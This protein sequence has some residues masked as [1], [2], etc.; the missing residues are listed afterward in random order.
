MGLIRFD[1]LLNTDARLMPK[2]II[3]PITA[4]SFTIIDQE[5]GE[6]H[7]DQ[8]EYEIVRRVIHTTADFDFKHLMRFSPGAIASGLSAIAQSQTII[9]DVGMVKQGIEG[10]AARTFGNPVVSALEYGEITELGHE[11][12]QTKSANGMKHCLQAYPQGIFAVGNAPT[13]LLAL[14]DAIQN[15]FA[16]N[17]VIGV[18]V[19][20]VSVLEAK[21]SLMSSKLPFICVEGR[22]GGSTVAAAIINALLVIAWQ[23]HKQV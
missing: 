6:H 14:C 8:F 18:P 23:K 11:L 21:S 5:I 7:F 13:A 20:F 1:E 4:Q 15:G 16:P 10:M 12:G 9:T 19:G 2:N 17:L 22:K 3:H